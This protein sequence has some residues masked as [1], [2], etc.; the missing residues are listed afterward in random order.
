MRVVGEQKKNVLHSFMQIPT[1][2][3]KRRR[4]CGLC[5]ECGT[6]IYR[7]SIAVLA[8]VRLAQAELRSIASIVEGR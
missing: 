7:Y 4:L 5:L 6:G 2:C 3:L 8:E 1:R